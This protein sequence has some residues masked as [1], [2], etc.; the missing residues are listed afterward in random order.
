M[1]D[2]KKLRRQGIESV[3]KKRERFLLG[4]AILFWSL[5]LLSLLFF[6]ISEVQAESRYWVASSASN[7]NNTSNWSATS[8]GSGGSSV[9]GSS[10]DVYFDS[11]RIGNCSIDATVNM[12]SMSISGYTGTITQQ[13]GITITITTSF[14]QSSGTFAGGDSA[15]D[16]NGNF[17]LSGGTFTSTSGVLSVAGNW[18]HPS[19]GTFT[20]NSGTITFDGSSWTSSDVN[21]TETFYNLTLNKSNTAYYVTIAYGDTFKITG[22]LSLTRGYFYGYGSNTFEAQGNVTVTA[23]YN[24]SSSVPLLFSGGNTQTFDLTGATDVFNAAI[25]INKSAGQVNLS[26]DLTMDAGYDLTLTAAT[27]NL[28]GHTV[29]ITGTL[30]VNGTVTI[31]GTG[32]LTSYTYSQSG[33]SGMTFSGASTFTVSTGGFSL[34]TGTFTPNDATVTVN[35][36]CTINSG[37]FNAPSGTMT[38]NGDFTFSSGTF[39]GGSGNLTVNGNFS[40][41]TG[42]FN[43]PS[44]YLDINGNFTLNSGIF[45]APTGNMYVSGNW[46]HPSAG[47]FNHNSGT[48]TFDGSSYAS[49]DVNTTETFYNLTLNKGA[50]GDTFKITGALSLTRGYFYAYGSNTLEAQ[51]NVTVGA[52]YNS[53]NSV[54]LLFSGGNTQTFDLT[55][56]TDV[57]NAAITINKSAG[58]VNLSSDL[59]MD[60]SGQTLTLTAAT[61]N[62]NSHTVT[63]NCSTCDPVTGTLTVNGTVTIAG[64]GTLAPYT[65]S[66]SGTSSM[67]FSGASAFTVGVGGF[68]LSTG[69][70]TPNSATVTISGNCTIDSSATF[71]AP[72]GDMTVGGIFTLTSGTF[73]APSG[74]MT[75]SGGFTITS[76]TY[77]GPSGNMTVNGNFSISTGTFYAPSGYLDI[78][79]NFTIN[80]GIFNAPTGNMYVAGNWSHPSAGTFNHNNGTVT[81][82]G[83]SYA[84]SDVN[85]TEIFYNLTL[86]KGNTA[87]YVTI[88]YGDTF[89]ITGALSLT[90]GYFYAYGS[91]TLEAQGNVTVGANYNSGNSVPLL[92]SGGNTQ[93]FDLTS[94]TDVFNASITI[95]KSAGQVNLSS[96]LT[97]D[98][99]GQTLTL[100]AATLNLNGHTVTVNCSTCDPMTGTVTVNGTVTVA[101]TGTLAPYWYSQSGTSIMTFSG[102]S[103]FTVGAGGFSLSSGDFTANGAT[104]TV[105]GDCTISPGTFNAPTGTM[106]VTGNFTFSSGTFNAG[107]GSM[108]VGGNFSASTGTFTAPSGSLDING[109]FTLSSGTFNA[110]SGNMYVA[111]NWSHTSSGTF[112]HNNGTVTFDGSSYV[113]SDVNTTETFYNLTLN[114]SNTAYYVIIST[115]DTLKT[116]G[117]LSLTQ[118]YFY[119]YSGSTLEAQGNVTVTTNYNTSSNVP[120]LFSGSNTQTFDLTGATNI[121]NANITV[122]K[123]GGEVDLASD[124]VMDADSQNLTLTVGTF[125]LSGKN[126]TVSGSG[127]SFTVQSGGNLQLQGGETITGTP[128]LNSGSTVTYDGTATSYTIKNYSYSNLTINGSSTFEL[129]A[130]LTVNSTLTITSGRLSQANTYNLT[131][132]AVTIGSNGTLRNWG[133]GSLTLGG[134]LSNSGTVDF[135]GGGDGICG[136]ATEVLIRS[137]INGTQRSWSGSGT[138]N[139]VDV[140]VKDQGGT[141]SITVY[142]GTNT[143]G[144]NGTNWTFNGTCTGAPTAI[145]LTSFSATSFGAEEVLLEW[146]TGYEVDNLGF[147]LYREENGQRLR[148]TPQLV[149]GSAFLTGTGTPLTAGRSYTWI[150]ASALSTESRP[151]PVVRYWLEDWDLNGKKTL[152]GPVTPVRSEKPLLKYGNPTLLSNLGKRQ[153]EK[154]DEFWR[155]QE[156]RERLHRTALIQGHPL[157]T[158]GGPPGI[159]DQPVGSSPPSGGKV[160]SAP[161]VTPEAERSSIAIHPAQ[162]TLASQVGVKIGVREEGWYRVTQPELI[163]AGLNPAADPRRLRLFVDADE[164]AMLVSGQGDGRFDPG[165]SIEFYGTGQDTPFTDTRVYWL[166]EG[167][168]LGKRIKTRQSIRGLDGSLSFPH[169][170]QLKERTIYIAAL[171]NGDTENFFGAVVTTEGVDQILSVTNLDPSPPG[172]ALLEVALQGATSAAHRVKVFLNDAEIMEIGFEGPVRKV[173]K[174]ALPQSWLMEGEN[175]VTLVAQEGEADISALDYIQLT[176]WHTYTAE[177]DMLRFSASA[178][179]QVAV[180]GFT[181]SSIRALDITNPRQ[182]QEVTGVV[183]SEGLGYTLRFGVTGIGKRTLLTFT[184]EAIKSPASI[185]YNQPSTWYK[186]NHRADLVIITHK[187]FIGSLGPLKSLRESQGWSVALIDVEDIYD[188]FSFGAKS[189]RAL[190]DFLYR[191]RA[192]WQRPPRFVLLVGD[193]SFDPRN[194]LGLGNFDL[195]PTKLIDTVCLETASDD[196]FV[197][198]NNDGMPVIPVGRIPVRTA[199]EAALVVSKIIA[200]DNAEAGAWADQVLS[201]ADKMEERDFFDFERA[202]TEVGS[203]LPESITVQQILR[204]QGD[205]QT[206]RTRIID[207]INEGKLLVNYIGHGSVE[208][209]RGDVFSSVDVATLTNGVRLPFI[210]TMTCLNGFFHDP[211]PTESLAES[212]LKAE[213]G[214]AIAV[215]ASSGL[216]EPEGQS[217]MNKELILLLFDGGSRTLGE[218]TM[219][220]KTATKDR[221]VRRTWILFGDPTTRLR[222]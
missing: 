81:F 125:A 217:V 120:L 75:V 219:K 158:R 1:S 9:P 59:T 88:A 211:F 97:M 76:G 166:T 61:L 55:G 23:N 2:F 37:T 202:S 180:N 90:R 187:D 183:Q 147:H 192:Y 43:A 107:S 30:T 190:R 218:A 89:K 139:M 31:A 16:I 109:N 82:D 49:S 60:A 135:N 146:R 204:S 177:E 103:T 80:S 72:P 132:G 118:G 92:F 197:D 159:E 117:A 154:Y 46:S 91:N 62:L 86:N 100:T 212:L 20:N 199:E 153:N 7:W 178:G 126:L 105:N 34:S 12:N 171:K 77:Y 184:E 140:D 152:H 101:G 123:A 179:R 213:E 57:F 68:S 45:N 40:I 64:T 186:V 113:S 156:L 188:E 205:D 210:I 220:A 39:T 32:T 74:N 121:F 104:V 29:T 14:S 48:V 176:Y 99:S 44:G 162:L 93:T 108:A 3:E 189:P 216:T 198:F 129:P 73:R 56:A 134:N 124:L 116:I 136:S 167:T 24:T 110:P 174:C 71:N 138:F 150:D 78:N 195:V 215:W 106:T 8:G 28:N 175:L 222:Q 151:S 26:S 161:Q 122:N 27:L 137:S 98:A 165:D 145:E 114:K 115:G 35:G 94:A 196:W 102:A 112:N 173:M 11:A 214:G 83:N 143:G 21:T 128:T 96:N 25:T 19:S 38:V 133:T 84:S 10:D 42:T 22:A 182:V 144:N 13:T 191:A 69:T 111:N 67:T 181:S 148:L 131:A 70:F 87:Y 200:Y 119:G 6:L 15:I 63:V 17:S 209:W 53:G 4:R 194:Y 155:I 207:G 185:T 170:V 52:N 206:T 203:L 141:A 193:A 172:N 50:Y 201:V 5:S 18:S 51:G 95:N 33:T 47:T 208:L 127:G 65:Y 41:S 160:R 54:P 163:A 221:D 36:A 85:T 79:G 169:T 168:Q 58:Q 164:Q 130:N 157:G 142:H 149:A 66:Q